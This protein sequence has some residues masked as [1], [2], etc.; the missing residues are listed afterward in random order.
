MNKLLAAFLK[1]V[2]A[3]ILG[4]ATVLTTVIMSP[5]LLIMWIWKQLNG[6]PRSE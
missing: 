1:I 4:A 2:F 3:G 5:L 6:P